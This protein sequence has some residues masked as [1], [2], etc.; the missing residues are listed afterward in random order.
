MNARG[1]MAIGILA[2][3]GAGIAAFA[4]REMSR[5][6]REKLAEI[7]ARVAPGATYFA[8]ERAGAHV[9]F[10]S[11][12]IDT[13]PG[14]LQVT[15]YLVAD[16]AVGG[17]MQR[18]TA[19]SVV[20]LS[21]GLALRD[22]TLTFGS[23]AQAVRATGRTVGDSILEYVVQA[24][25]APGD[26]SRV[27]LTGPLLLPTLVPLA[28]ALGEPPEV[29]NTYTIET[30]DPTTM[31]ARAMPVSIRAESLFVLVDSAAFDPNS[32][33]WLGAHAD[34]VRG[35]RVTA[36]DGGSFDTWIDEMG[37]MI[38]MQAPAGISMRRTAYEVAFE[39]WRTASPLR[40]RRT[41]PT[42][43]LWS[44]TAISAGVLAN[45]PLLDTLQLRVRGVDLAR[46]PV[47]GG[48]QTVRGD[49]V[50]IRRDSPLTLRP[51][52]PLPPSAATRARFARELRAEPLLEVEHPAIVALAKRLKGR[53]A[54]AD[55]VTQRLMT[56]VHDSLAKEPSVTLPS[57]VATLRSRA[58]DCN[59]HAQLFVALARA[60][61]IP[62]RTISGVVAIDGKFYYHA[63][64][65]VM[66]QRWVGVDPTLGQFPT[67]AS[68]LRLLTGGLAA[69]TE[70][71]RVI[72]R[73]DLT[74]LSHAAPPTTGA[75]PR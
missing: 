72:G 14:G 59:E 64:A 36:S 44:V 7:A 34:T 42:E 40:A 39:N 65:E 26:T 8:V 75:T 29:G 25:G 11:N 15:D 74:V 22:F 37:R 38:T 53:D 50:M 61:G 9:G 52:F 12:T 66:L 48:S 71:A 70:L 3:W 4:Q 19:Q 41:E 54:M 23:D 28:V 43:D 58:G 30:F 1:L 45:V 16:L 2:A 27:R 46:L 60:V 20:R 13:I 73:L 18:T 62:A 63:W 35:F 51:S 49:T 68:H 24:P 56:W 47:H 69:Q 31:S 67:D 5:S 57:A 33:R 6:P 17:T 55:A 10:A 32:R 21:R